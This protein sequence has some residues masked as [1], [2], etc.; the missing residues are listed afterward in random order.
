MLHSHSDIYAVVQPQAEVE[1]LR[2]PASIP[3]R[4]FAACLVS[5]AMAVHYTDYGPLIPAMLKDLH[6]E[7]SQAG[8]LSTLLFLGLALT[9]VP[10]GLLVDR[11]GQRPVLLGAMV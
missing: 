10:G 7:A 6:I 5:L 3:M 1:K 8:L 11:Y 4:I 2:R 9:Y